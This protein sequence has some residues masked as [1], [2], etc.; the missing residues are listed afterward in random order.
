LTAARTAGAAAVCK[1]G[2]VTVTWVFKVTYIDLW[3]LLTYQLYSISVII[4]TVHLSS[5]AR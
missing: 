4:G 1:D 3:Y 5:L 2:H